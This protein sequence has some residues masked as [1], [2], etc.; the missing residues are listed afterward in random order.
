MQI[1]KKKK[2]CVLHQRSLNSAFII[3]LLE[4]IISNFI[5]AKI[6]FSG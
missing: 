4:S 2:R 3:H 5:R 6:Q 1:S